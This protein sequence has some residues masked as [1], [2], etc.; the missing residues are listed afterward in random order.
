MALGVFL[1]GFNFV[2]GRQDFKMWKSCSVCGRVHKSGERC[3]Q[4]KS[5]K[6]AGREADKFRSSQAWKDKREQVRQRD[7]FMCRWCLHKAEGK[8][9]TSEA[10]NYRSLQVHHITPLDEDYSLRLEDSNL[11]TLCPLCHELAER[12]DISRGELG[13]LVA[14]NANVE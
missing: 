6:K 5:F 8:K 1:G 13:E 7:R 11:I 10:V 14:K 9:L 12:G 3:P 2:K 4:K